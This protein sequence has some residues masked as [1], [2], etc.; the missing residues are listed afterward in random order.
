MKNKQTVKMA[1]ALIVLVAAI[2]IYFGMSMWNRSEEEQAVAESAE[3]EILSI[4][5]EDVTAFSYVYNDETYKFVKEDGT[6]YYDSDRNF[7]WIKAPLK[8]S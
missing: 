6:W 8:E 4:S 2:G 1:A 7:R 5:G 3:T